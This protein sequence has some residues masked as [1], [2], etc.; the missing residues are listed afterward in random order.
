MLLNLSAV[1][2]VRMGLF[3]Y[4]AG[5]IY[6]TYLIVM[7]V[8][9]YAIYPPDNFSAYE[10]V[11]VIAI[12][13]LSL[14]TYFQ[15]KKQPFPLNRQ[16]AKENYDIFLVF[17]AIFLIRL[18]YLQD[19]SVWLDE[20]A[21]ANASVTNYF[22]GGGAG[23][24]QP[25]SD[26]V[27][28]RV[29]VLLTGFKVWG[30]RIHSALFSS[31]ATASLYYFVK[32]YSRSTLLA[33]GL[34]LLFAFHIVVVRFGFEA[35]PIS[36]GLFLEILFLTAFFSVFKNPDKSY[37]A[38]KTWFL[39][40]LTF[41]YLCSLGMQPAFVVGGA[42]IFSFFYGLKHRIV[43]KKVLHPMFIGL[44]AYLPIQ[45]ATYKLAEARFT[46]VGLFS[47]DA[48]LNQLSLLQYSMLAQYIEPFLFSFYILT[49]VYFV[50]ALYKKNLKVGPDFFFLFIALFFSIVFM[51][52][53]D[54]HIA[55]NLQNYYLV[56]AL[57]LAIMSLTVSFHQAV[58]ITKLNSKSL[59]AVS[60]AVLALCSIR[61]PLGPFQNLPFAYL[62][63]D[64]QGALTFVQQDPQKNPIVLALCLNP[65]KAWCA[66][67]VVAAKY[68]L[69]KNGLTDVVVGENSMN[70]L[71][72]INDF[73]KIGNVYFTYYNLWSGPIPETISN[74]YKIKSFLG[75]DV[76][77]TSGGAGFFQNIVDFLKPTIDDQLKK[78][79]LHTYALEYILFAY[80]KTNNSVMLL[81]YLRIFKDFK[82]E[83][84]YTDYINSLLQKN[85]I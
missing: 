56:S 6:L 70:F 82:G 83:K 25:P 12:L 34:S 24:H 9:G 28:T 29:G 35:R 57:P 78:G 77:K 66:P 41:L 20:D 72:S 84:I 76:Y 5:L 44:V 16:L 22:V 26:F 46:R 36:H 63:N 61:Y 31:L 47:M 75:V 27:F 53:F 85:G 58:S 81:N 59:L 79:R 33:L 55:W 67:F 15:T 3:T 45:Y 30:L 11:W 37:L 54:S 40:V 48:F 4:I 32:R 7:T 71:L 50:T 69:P 62:Q 39:S 38:D 65:E 74:E 52:Y 80:E 73:T 19:R 10:S 43:A 2:I 18:F 64:M 42:L 21:Q 13:A 1:S 14:I 49:V 60:I 17:L 23:H 8:I 51:A 68:Y